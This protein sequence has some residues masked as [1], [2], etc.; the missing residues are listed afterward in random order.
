MRE[1]AAT[2]VLDLNSPPIPVA[3]DEVVD[4]HLE[5]P[6]F[7]VGRYGSKVMKKW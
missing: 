5:S 1:S 6:D 2:G 4:T 3:Q 7:T